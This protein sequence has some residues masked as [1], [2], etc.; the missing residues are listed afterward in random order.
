[1]KTSQR[2]FLS[3]TGLVAFLLLWEGLAR[4][5][6]IEPHLLPPPSTLPGTLRSEVELGIWL[7]NGRGGE[8]D[9]DE[10]RKWFIK[11]AAQGNV[12]AQNRLARIYGFGVGVEKDIIKAGAWYILARRAGFTDSNMDRFFQSLSEIDKKRAIEAANQLGRRTL[13][14]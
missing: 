4:S 12:I 8:V 9:R 13:I 11:A 1:M 10:A 2:Y 3:S 14:R 6:W 7:A 5:G